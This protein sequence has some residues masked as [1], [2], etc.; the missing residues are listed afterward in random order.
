VARV[1]CVVCIGDRRWVEKE[2][3]EERKV[4]EGKGGDV[5]SC[6]SGVGAQKQFVEDSLWS[7]DFYEVIFLK[8]WVV[9]C[10]WHQNVF[11]GEF[12]LVCVVCINWCHHVHNQALITMLYNG[13]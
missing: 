1:I 2:K 5:R 13:H 4:L 6:V 8:L 11:Q 9:V 3:D 10:T 12:L 7:L